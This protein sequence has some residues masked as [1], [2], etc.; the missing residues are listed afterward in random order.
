M[1][2]NFPLLIAIIGAGGTGF[3]IWYGIRGWKR[4]TLI[5]GTETSFISGILGGLVEVKG[6]I[7][8]K[9]SELLESPW[10]RTACIYYRFKVEEKRHRTTGRNRTSSYWH[11]I[12]D[13]REYAKCAVDDGTGTIVV[14]LEEADLVLDRDAHA[15]SGLF[16]SGPPGIEEVLN[17]RYG[18]SSRGLIFN[19][20]MRYHETVLEPGDEIY[21]LGD[22]TVTGG[23]EWRITSRDHPLIVSDRGERGATRRFF[24]Q[25]I[26]SMIGAVVV[27]A[28]VL[29]F[30]RSSGFF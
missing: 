8:P 7:V 20:S 2:G 16:A 24:W 12:I 3:L 4:Y 27:A 10:T 25:A 28:V 29:S 19:K 15:T 26:L 1:S 6:T 30:L 13:D 21:V 17:E 18:Q 22:V 11:K 9:E 5:T 23:G 14:D